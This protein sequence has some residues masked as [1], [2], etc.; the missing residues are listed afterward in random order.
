MY[1]FALK[2]VEKVTDSVAIS[3]IMGFYANPEDELIIE[4]EIELFVEDTSFEYSIR[5]IIDNSV[6]D[7]INKEIRINDLKKTAKTISKFNESIDFYE[8][9]LQAAIYY[10]LVKH[11]Y[12]KQYKDYKIVFR[13]IVVD[14]FLQVG[15]ILVSDETMKDWIIKT[16]DA[17]QKA[18]YHFIERNFDLP[19][20]FIKNGG[21]ITI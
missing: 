18:N 9:W 21:E 10:M 1:D 12:E 3:K 6:I 17:L 4:N 14:A 8:Y 7:N 13:F 16:D 19:Y 2:A 5:G 11:I 20:E 15:S